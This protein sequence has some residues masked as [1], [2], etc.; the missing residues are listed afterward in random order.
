MKKLPISIFES[1]KQYG[2]LDYLKDHQIDLTEEE[3]K[4]FKDK[5]LTWEDGSQVIH[6][7]HAKDEKDGDVYFAW[8]HRA[9]QVGKTKTEAVKLGKFIMTTS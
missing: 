8:T 3:K 4:Y 2:G 9:W 1:G 6:K 7:A 5:G